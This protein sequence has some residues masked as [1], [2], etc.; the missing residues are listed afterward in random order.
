M[1]GS[2]TPIPPGLTHPLRQPLNT[3]IRALWGERRHSSAITA[4]REA[5]TSRLVPSCS[6]HSPYVP[7]V[8]CRQDARQCLGKQKSLST[9]YFPSKVNDPLCQVYPNPVPWAP[10]PVAVQTTL[11]LSHSYRAVH[12]RKSARATKN[13]VC[14][15]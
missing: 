1:A 12:R 13:T 9:L 6:P 4:G 7:S 15:I 5:Q 3:G 8:K 14:S 11:V 2:S 10:W